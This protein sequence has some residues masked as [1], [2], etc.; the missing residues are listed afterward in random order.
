MSKK[1]QK[2]LPKGNVGR[3][4]CREKENRAHERAWG[5][6]VPEGAFHEDYSPE[7]FWAVL[8][9]SVRIAVYSGGARLGRPQLVDG[10]SFQA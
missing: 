6:N 7:R 9:W 3:K 8:A 1:L 4:R 10:V 2:L 5:V